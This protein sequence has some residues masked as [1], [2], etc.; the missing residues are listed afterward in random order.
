MKNNRFLLL[1]I[2]VLMSI[3]MS[4]CG[5]KE[6][7]VTRD[8]EALHVGYISTGFPAVF[9]PWLS[10][11]GIATELSSMI[12]STLFAYDSDNDVFDPLLG[13]SWE[14]L[15]DPTEVPED[16]DYLTVKI[17]LNKEAT[18]SDGTPVTP[19]DVYF[20]FDLAS[21]FS[22]SSHA[23]TLAWTGDLMHDYNSDY[24]GELIRQG[25][26]TKDHP[27]DYTF[28]DEDDH[29]VYL[30]VKKVLGGITPLFTTILILPEHQYNIISHVNKLNSTNP[31]SA[32]STLYNNPMG[33]GPFTLDVDNSGPGVI[34]LNR[35]DDYHLKDDNG[36]ILYKVESIK[37]I[38][39]LD[40]IVAINALQEGDIDVIDNS[41]SNIYID[42]LNA[43]KNVEVDSSVNDFVS[44]LCINLNVPEE[45]ST[46]QRELLKDPILRE[47]IML[48]LDQ[49]YLITQSLDGEG[50]S[51]R[52]GLFT[53]NSIYVNDS[54]SMDD[55]D[56]DKANQIL[57]D[58][59]YTFEAGSKFRSKDGVLLDYKITGSPGVKTTI[60]YIQVLFEQIGIKIEYHEGG[61]NPTKDY[62]YIGNF[63]MTI[64][65]VVFSMVNVDM[66]FR[67]QFVTIGY[68]SNYGRLVDESFEAKIN[69]MRTTLDRT[70]KIELIFE[71]QE[72]L[73]SMNYKIPLYTANTSSAYRTDIF[74]GW[75][76]VDN[77]LIFNS[78]SLQNLTLNSK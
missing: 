71:I 66:M 68:S 21:D 11:Q 23:G 43:V 64:Q 53:E 54:I 58:A 33:S 47:A 19:E 63:D 9:M 24:S 35:R 56:L 70:R 8:D 25:I 31:T 5:E 32:Q 41:I 44:T 1:L 69:E 75:V 40:E 22:R 76:H 34:I 13:D 38:N 28:T 49:D 6:D 12:F 27:G 55:H 37:F 61:T 16:Q 17:N 29:V 39:Y 42:T 2:I 7:S 50:S 4:S 20:S 26:F 15:V 45:Y 48:A 51:V 74:S 59:G 14:Y 60:N 67:A 18:W 46:P 52:G 78:D 65:N 36:D 30:H 72:D 73:D 10:N 3:V 57:E 77:V 62:F